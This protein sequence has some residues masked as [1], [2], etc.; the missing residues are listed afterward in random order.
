MG[1]VQIVRTTL[2]DILDEAS[3][4]FVHSARYWVND[5]T[6]FVIILLFLAA[7][8]ALFLER[9]FYYYKGGGRPV[10]SQ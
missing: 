7:N 5:G 8:L 3:H 10:R 9:F 2:Q 4:D 1:P 6:K